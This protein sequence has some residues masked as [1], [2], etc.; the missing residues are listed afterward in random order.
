MLDSLDSFAIALR[1]ALRPQLMETVAQT[2]QIVQGVRRA[3][4][5]RPGQNLLLQGGI[6]MRQQQALRCADVQRHAGAD[7]LGARA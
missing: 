7:P 6:G 4:F 1:R 3:G 5:E 2:L